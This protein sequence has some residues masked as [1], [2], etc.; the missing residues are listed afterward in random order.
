MPAVNTLSEAL[1]NLY[2]T[3]WLHQKAEAVDNIFTSIPFWAWMKENGR[4]KPVSG[5]RQILEAVEYAKNDSVQFIGKGGTVPLN[6]REFLTQAVWDWHYL[7]ASLVR[8]GTDDQKNRGKTKIMDLMNAKLNN[9]KSSLTDTLETSLFANVAP[10]IGGA[11]AGLRHLVQ[12]DPTAAVSVGG[13]AQNT[14]SWW[15]NQF[16]DDTSTTF[17]TGVLQNMRT[18]RNRCMNNRKQDSPDII[19]TDQI[20]YELYEGIAIPTT[21]IAGVLRV[22]NTKMLDLGFDSQAFKGIPM[23]WSPECPATKMYFLNTNF[24]YWIYDPGLYFDMTEWK[25]IP[26]QVNDK[27]AQIVSACSFVTSRRRTQGVLFGLPTA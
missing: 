10:T 15:R 11:F 4:M 3:T 13:I 1:D 2:T 27:A 21:N 23:V 16:L 20:S 26:D 25:P 18:M 7:V 5:G 22:Q 9:A 17:A 14:Y 8:F 24:L 6:D 12:D 19:V